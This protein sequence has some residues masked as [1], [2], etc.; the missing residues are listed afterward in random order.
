MDHGVW[1]R[2]WRVI[3]LLIV[4]ALITIVFMCG[5]YA[6]SLVAYLLGIQN[7]KVAFGIRIIDIIHVL[8]ALNLLV[9]GYWALRHLIEA[10]GG[11]DAL[12]P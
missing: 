3:Q 8:H 6:V 1:R 4:D 5:L 11:R 7:E 10:D 9:N 2:S 12:D